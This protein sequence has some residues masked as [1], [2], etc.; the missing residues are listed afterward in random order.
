MRF[1]GG[2]YGVGWEICRRGTRSLLVVLGQGEG[3]GGRFG[4][5]V[6]GFEVRKPC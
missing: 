2:L 3:S 6:F 4:R 5:R 1:G